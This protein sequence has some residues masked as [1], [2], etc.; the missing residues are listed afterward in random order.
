MTTCY[1]HTQ[2]PRIDSDRNALL[3][4]NDLLPRFKDKTKQNKK[5][6][7]NLVQHWDKTEGLLKSAGTQDARLKPGSVPGK[8]GRL[9]T[10]TVTEKYLK[11]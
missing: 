2:G 9:L 10:L 3:P 4:L 5:P 8:P 6:E 1:G 7:T 11:Y